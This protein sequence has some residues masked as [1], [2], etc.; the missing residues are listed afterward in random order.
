MRA[1]RGFLWLLSI[2]LTVLALVVG[3]G[4]WGASG[5]VTVEGKLIDVHSDDF[6][7]G[8]ATHRYWLETDQGTYELRFSQSPVLPLASKVRVQGQRSGGSIAVA[9]GGVTAAAGST[10]TS[11]ATGAKRVA[12]ILFT[13]SDN[14]TQPYTPAFAQG[15][16]F[17]NTNW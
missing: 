8:Q 14:S 4:A 2:P 7:H 6:A 17:T 15:V 10:T 5:E 13:F 9:A 12:V 11:T 16:A 3:T 1:A